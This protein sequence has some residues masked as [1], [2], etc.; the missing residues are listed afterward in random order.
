[1]KAIM[2]SRVD[3]MYSLLRLKESDPAGYHDR[4][5]FGARHTIQ[6]DEPAEPGS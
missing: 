1:M 4:I 3:R 6:W 2:K 5:I